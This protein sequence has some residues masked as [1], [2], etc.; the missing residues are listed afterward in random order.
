MM[1]AKVGALMTWNPGDHITLRWVGHRSWLDEKNEHDRTGVVTEKPGLL[2]AWPH[3]VVEDTPELLALSLPQGTPTEIIDLAQPKSD[4]VHTT[5]GVDTVR[6]MFPGKAYSIRLEWTPD[7]Y[8]ER[9][10]KPQAL[11]AE[12]PDP[13]AYYRQRSHPFAGIPEHTFRGWVVNLEA[14]FVRTSIGVDSTDGALDVLVAPDYTWRWKNEQYMPTLVDLGIYR[15]QDVE[16]FRA[17]GEDAIKLIE[18][19]QF[20]FDGSYL[21]WHAPSDWTIPQAQPGW[22]R[23]PGY[24]INL[25]TGRSITPELL[26]S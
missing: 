14:P 3:V 8:E 6:L 25:M 15:E 24:S 2:Q 11:Y 20:P 5:W 9:P 18:S 10:K 7:P 22:E 1:Y 23:V 4:R 26:A 21:D 13:S 19:R 16:A 12:Q 17:A